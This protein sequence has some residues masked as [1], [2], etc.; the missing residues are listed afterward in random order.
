MKKFSTLKMWGILLVVFSV[1]Q[2]GCGGGGGDSESLTPPSQNITG[3]YS[4]K[5]FTI[6]YSNGYT[7][8]EK[9][10][11]FSATMKLGA[12]TL[13]ISGVYNNIPGSSSGTYSITY[14]DGTS[15]GILHFL[16]SDAN[17]NWAIGN[18]ANGLYHAGPAS[19]VDM[20]FS[21]SGN[22]ITIHSSGGVPSISLN[23]GITYENWETW[24]KV[25]N[26][27]QE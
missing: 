10:I 4:L 20:S 5:S 17:G 7:L 14:T 12:E 19:P 16:R 6:A 11:P 22:D 3:T 9:D 1:L 18:G 26:S 2:I 8:T 13:S 25:S 15:V 27:I 21:V 24:E 23:G